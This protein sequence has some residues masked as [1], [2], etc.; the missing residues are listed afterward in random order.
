MRFIKSL[1][2]S[3]FLLFIITGTSFASVEEDCIK[4]TNINVKSSNVLKTL[5]KDQRLK[6][7][8]CLFDEKYGGSP[9][10]EEELI[11]DADSINEINYVSSEELKLLLKKS[12]I[13]KKEN[14][15]LGYFDRKAII[16]LKSDLDCS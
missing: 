2:L 10:N 13:Y 14:K 3:I 1:L 4:D 9:K 12:D 11:K 8:Y 5:T 6:F 7:V 15:D 16:E